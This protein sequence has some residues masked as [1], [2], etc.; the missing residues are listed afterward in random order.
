M[1]ELQNPLSRLLGIFNDLSC[2]RNFEMRRL[3]FVALKLQCIT[4]FFDNANTTGHAM[5]EKDIFKIGNLQ[6][7]Y[8]LISAFLQKNY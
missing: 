5:S 4:C 1:Q 6:R 8:E 3:S 2:T 7:M